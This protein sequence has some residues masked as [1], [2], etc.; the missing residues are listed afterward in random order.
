MNS[1]TSFLFLTARRSHF[2]CRLR[3][4]CVL[5]LP[6]HLLFVHFFRIV[7]VDVGTFLLC[8]NALLFLVVIQDDAQILEYCRRNLVSEIFDR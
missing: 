8:D 4:S 6:H 1:R 3:A 7:D 2:L 5:P